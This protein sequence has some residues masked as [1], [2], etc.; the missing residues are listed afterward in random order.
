MFC[1]FWLL[2]KYGINRIPCYS[3]KSDFWGPFQFIPLKKE[4]SSSYYK[5]NEPILSTPY[6][7]E[8]SFLQISSWRFVVINGKTSFAA[9]FKT[10]DLNSEHEI[11]SNH[12]EY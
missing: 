1:L 4:Y 6:S 11:Y 12:V 9:K 8:G 5:W 3:G 10:W 2:Q 7:L